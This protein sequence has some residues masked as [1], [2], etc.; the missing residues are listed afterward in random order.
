MTDDEDKKDRKP[1]KQSSIRPDSHP[2]SSAGS[3]IAGA[4]ARPT[5]PL[6]RDSSVDRERDGSVGPDGSKTIL[7]IRRLVS[8]CIITRNRVCK[9]S[10]TRLMG[11]GKPKSSAIVQ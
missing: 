7:R 6:S 5:P 1:Q 8:T 4:S 9:L 3:P 10:L 11:F 2:Y